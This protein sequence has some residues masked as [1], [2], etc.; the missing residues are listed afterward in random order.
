MRADFGAQPAHSFHDTTE[1]HRDFAL[2]PDAEL[3]SAA[4]FC[5]RA[6]CANQCLRWNTANI[7]A[8]A[9]E[10]VPFHQRDLCAQTR[11]ACRR[12]EPRRASTNDDEIVTGRWFGIHPIR[13][14]N[15]HHKH[16]IV[17]VPGLHKV[18]WS[19]H[20]LLFVSAVTITLRELKALLAMR[21]RTSVT[22]TVA[23]RPTARSTHCTGVGR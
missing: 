8:V 5:G 3:I 10:Q 13:R 20:E 18:R 7:K 23:M 6:S 1:I 2:D 12:D 9:T 16:L 22:A 11:R 15:V 4:C 21:V 14:V 19:T 17:L